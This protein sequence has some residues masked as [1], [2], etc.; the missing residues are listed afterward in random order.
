MLALY[1]SVFLKQ[2][3]PRVGMLNECKIMKGIRK[4]PVLKAR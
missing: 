2:H 4:V 1:T 3:L